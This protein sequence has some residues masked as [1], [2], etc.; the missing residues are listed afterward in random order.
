MQIQSI[1]ISEIMT[2]TST[3]PSSIIYEDNV[4]GVLK[5]SEVEVEKENIEKKFITS[6]ADIEVHRKVELQDANISDEQ[7]QAFK[8]LCMKFN[9]IFSTDSGDIGKTPLLEVEIDT[10]DSLPITKKPYTL[11]LKHTEWVQ[12]ELEILEKAGVI[13][14]SV[15]PLASP[16]VVVPKRTALGEP[17]KCRLCVNYRALNSLLP[18]VKKAFSKAKGILTLV[19]LPK[20]D[21][22]Y[23]RL[24][25]SNV[26]ST[27]DMRSGYYH[28]VLSEK[29]RPKSAFVSSFGK[30][31]FKR[32][33]FGLAQA[34]AYFQRLVNEVLSGLTFGFSYLDDILVYSPDMETHL[35]HLRKLFMK[36]REA[37]LKLKEV[38]CNFLKKHIQY[39]GHIVL[40]KGITPM[41]EK[42]E[43]IKE[44]PPPKTPKEV[45]QFLGLTGY[46]WKFIPRFSDLARPLN[47]LTRKDVPFEWTPICQESF[48]LLK[49]SLMTEPILTYPDPNHPYVLFTD[50]SK[51]AWACVLTQEKTHQIEGKEVKIL[52]PIMYMSGHFHGSQMNWACLTKEAYAIY[53]SI[54]KLAYYLE[55]ADITLRSDHLPLKKFLVKNTLNSKV[56]NW[57]IEISPFCITFKYIKGIKNTL[58]DT[59]SRLININPQIQQDSEP[60]GY[61]FGYYTFDTLPAIEVSNINTMKETP[62]ENEEDVIENIVKLPISDDM[63]SGLQL[64]DMF[65]SHII[66]Q[67]KKGNIKEGQMYKMQNNLLKRYVTDSDKMYETVILP[68]A[69]IAQVLKMAHDDLGHNGT[70]R[71]Y[72]LLKRLYYW[73]GLK[74]SVVIHIQRCYHCQQR[75]KQVVKYATLHFDV[76]TFP[77]QFISM[78]LIGEFHP[79]TS[80]GKKYALTIICMLMGYIFCIPRRTKT[81]EEILQA[82]IDNMYSKFGGSLKIL[83]DNGTKFK[84]KIFEQIA[85][86]LGVVYKL[87]TPPYHP[88]SNGRIEGFH[89]FL[90]ACISKQISPQLE[91]D[92]VVPLA[93][94]AYNFLPNE[95]SKESSFFLMFGRDPVLPLNTL[96][97]P[98]IRYMGTDI[99]IISLETM[100]NLLQILNWPG[101]R[102]ILKNNL[103]LQNCSPETQS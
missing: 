62:S 27:F 42:L 78:D 102:G 103:S 89:A 34:P 76:A 21:E 77:M 47:T 9:D 2:E 90:K 66:A 51:Y 96:L 69:L 86:E 80:K 29:S 45:K 65:C 61:E 59:M 17:P 64:Q 60:E 100:K 52:H 63:L 36:L 88:A 25:G 37:D 23:A 67:I 93:C 7:Q 10:G 48:K 55:D 24:K 98:K 87:Y 15:S 53:M 83:S 41:P 26:Y 54:K 20:I 75:N 85:K 70:H 33:P 91:W 101:K 28:M 16:I 19:P 92:D 49:T 58:A 95:H 79:P 38:K 68:R 11:P 44:M 6:P 50:A 99:N 40:G 84:N 56:N 74:P 22:I 4:N 13:V 94:A 97:E 72:M 14:R 43:C 3:E 81:A 1:E 39:L 12:R 30:W 8:D 18:P 57:A 31:E 35:E 73:K 5:E 32:C 71:T 82:Y 46:Y